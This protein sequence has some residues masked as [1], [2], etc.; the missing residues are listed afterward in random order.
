MSGRQGIRSVFGLALAL[1]LGGLGC[2]EASDKPASVSGRVTYKGKAVTSGIVVLVGK[3]GKVSDPGPVQADGTYKIAKAPVGPMKVSFDNPPPAHATAPPGQKLP[4]HDPEAQENAK[5][6][7]RYVATP[8]KF[9]DPEH[10]GVT[11]EIK[12]GKNE[13]CDIALK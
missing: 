7:A 12:K 13:N 3:D 4:A 9:K 1:V 6:S 11:L 5:E 8:A 10:S 2:G